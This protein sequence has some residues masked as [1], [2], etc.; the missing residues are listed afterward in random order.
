MLT[1]AMIITYAMRKFYKEKFALSR[2]TEKLL[3]KFC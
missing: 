2:I 3:N 1:I